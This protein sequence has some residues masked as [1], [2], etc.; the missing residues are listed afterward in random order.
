MELELVHLLLVLIAARARKLFKLVV[1]GV[2]LALGRQGAAEILF[3]H[4][5][6]A[7]NEVA[8]VV[9]KVGVYRGYKQLV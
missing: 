9:C 1:K 7:R 8:Q 2:G 4:C 6:R 5:G 3:D